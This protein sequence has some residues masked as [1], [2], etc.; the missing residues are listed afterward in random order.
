M[1]DPTPSDEI[2]RMLTGY[3]VSQAVY[4]AAELGIA[5]QLADGPRTADELAEATRT[6]PRS[7]YRLLRALASLGL[8]IESDGHRFA[9]A[10]TGE[11]LQS[12]VQGSQRATAL[13][14]VGQFYEAWGGLLGS[15]RIGRPAFEAIHGRPFFEH[16]AANPEQCQVFDAAMT[17][18]NDRKTRAMLETYDLSGVRVL[19][20]I[21][22]GTGST[23]ISILRQ[24]PGMRGVLFDLPGV[25]GRAETE[26]LAA[27]LNDRCLVKGGSFLEEVPG[28]ADAY[29]LRHILHNWDD[30]WAV[31]IL[32]NVRSAMGVEEGARLLVV[33]RLIPPG[34]EPMFGKLTDLTM[35]VVHGGLERTEE[36]FRDLFATAG[37]TLTR[38]VPT[39]SDV[40][41]IEGKPDEAA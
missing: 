21:G 12:G 36:E 2:A 1:T 18:F 27:G 3:W 19:A 32:R 34:N 29:L 33:E 41:V 22:G 11:C 10:P 24:Y 23:L 28:G 9:L 35:L 8:F 15:V 20:D 6:H 17:A 14:M 26:V 25:A 31:A 5:D 38:V 7:L 4:V 39:S 16:L 13:M 40:S 37:F 30:G